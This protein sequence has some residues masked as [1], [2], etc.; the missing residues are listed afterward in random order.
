MLRKK[1]YTTD[2]T[3][4]TCA[5]T[6]NHH[7]PLRPFTTNILGRLVPPNN[8]IFKRTCVVHPTYLISDDACKN[9]LSGVLAFVVFSRFL[10]HIL[11]WT[12]WGHWA[13]AGSGKS[14]H[15]PS[16]SKHQLQAEIF[17]FNQIKYYVINVYI[18]VCTYPFRPLDQVHFWAETLLDCLVQTQRVVSIALLKHEDGKINQKFKNYIDNHFNKLHLLREGLGV[19]FLLWFTM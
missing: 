3:N 17:T 6:T 14:C 13:A 19:L 11:E 12:F 16:H 4:A 18:I 8:G 1:V 15:W 10:F 5:T 7:H 9:L 2:P